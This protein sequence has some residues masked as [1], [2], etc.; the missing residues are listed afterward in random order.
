MDITSS[1]ERHYFFSRVL[2]RE[3]IEPLPG[4]EDRLL[5]SFYLVKQ[6][7]CWYDHPWDFTYE[8]SVGAQ[9]GVTIDYR[10]RQVYTTS[11][12][13]DLRIM[14]V[15]EEEMPSILKKVSE[16]LQSAIPHRRIL[17]MIADVTVRL[18]GSFDDRDAIENC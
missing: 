14:D 11:F 6:S 17:V 9:T 10:R 12:S 13:R 5:I 18:L 7:R 4:R 16:V 8:N 3:T 1:T 2:Q 15:P